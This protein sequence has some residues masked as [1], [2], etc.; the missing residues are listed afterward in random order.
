MTARRS[1]LPDP[2]WELDLHG[3][4]PERA[5]QLVQQE[6]ALRNPRGHS[7]GRIITGRGNHSVVGKSPV[8]VAV[9][10]FLHSPEA[11]A[12]GVKNVQPD[13]GGGAFIVTLYGPSEAPT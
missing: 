6:I 12:L 4:T 2:L 10:R 11:R 3:A 5:I 1:P 9:K 7:P 13:K 8:L